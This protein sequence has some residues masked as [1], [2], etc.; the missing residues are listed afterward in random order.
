MGA[1]CRTEGLLLPRMGRGFSIR[2]VLL[3]RKRKRSSLLAV[4][5]SESVFLLHLKFFIKLVST[6]TLPTFRINTQTI[7]QK[8][9]LARTL[10]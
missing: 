10:I 3:R 8:I 9:R 4:E 5:S 1:G 2:G 6:I 7:A